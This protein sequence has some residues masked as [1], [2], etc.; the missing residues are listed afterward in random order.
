MILGVY[1]RKSVDSKERDSS[2]IDDQK[3]AGIELAKSL[4]MEHRFFI[5][6]TSSGKLDL[7]P[8]SDP[9]PATF[10]QS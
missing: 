5:E 3:Q 4:G 8:Q 1:C 7:F 2:S 10:F 9:F 6:E